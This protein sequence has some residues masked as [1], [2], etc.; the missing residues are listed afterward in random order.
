MIFHRVHK[1]IEGVSPIFDPAIKHFILADSEEQAHTRTVVFAIFASNFEFFGAS[2]WTPV[3]QVWDVLDLCGGERGWVIYH[4]NQRLRH[5]KVS[6]HHGDFFACYERCAS[7]PP[8]QADRPITDI[9]QGWVAN[10]PMLIPSDDAGF[11]PSVPT[12]VDATGSAQNDVSPTFE[13]TGD[14][15]LLI[16]RR[17]GRRRRDDRAVSFDLDSFQ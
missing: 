3:T 6:V 8:S 11:A 16:G 2:H 7:T 17:G 9:D 15:L 10:A 12:V 5:R 4:N 14:P 13:N 1:A